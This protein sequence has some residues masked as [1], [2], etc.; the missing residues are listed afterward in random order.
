MHDATATE[1]TDK[2]L[3]RYTR[4][5]VWHLSSPA[6]GH[7]NILGLEVPVRLVHFVDILHPLGD[8]AAQCDHERF[9][10][11]LIRCIMALI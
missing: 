7:Q 5:P 10:V 8:L 3:T 11:V 9:T 1:Q 6:I 4:H 2:Q